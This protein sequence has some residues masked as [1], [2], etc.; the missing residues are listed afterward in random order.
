M[1]AEIQKAELQLQ[2]SNTTVV[3][4]H[5]IITNLIDKFYG[6]KTRLILN[7]LKQIDQAKSEELTKSFE[8]LTW[9]KCLDVDKLHNEFCDIKYLYDNLNKKNIKLNDQINSYISSKTNSISSSTKISL[10]CITFDDADD[11]NIAQVPE[12]HNINNSIRSDQLWSF[13]L[14][15]NPNSA[16][17]LYKMICYLFSIPYVQIRTLNRSLAI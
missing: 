9:E 15:Y 17:N 13:L 12:D 7:Q 4:L 10:E 5:F 3:D 6:N 2:R 1:L 11:E 16:P 8:F 14:N